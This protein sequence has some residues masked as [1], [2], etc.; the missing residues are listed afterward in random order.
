[1][2]KLRLYRCTDA[3][4]V[5]VITLGVA[6]SIRHI[7]GP[8]GKSNIAANSSICDR[9]NQLTYNAVLMQLALQNKQSRHRLV[10]KGT[11]KPGST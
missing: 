6:P 4:A 11:A 1:M 3:L 8:T 2:K 10:A 7:L 5:E 9:L